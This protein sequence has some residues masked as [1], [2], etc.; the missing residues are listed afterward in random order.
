MG[1]RKFYVVWVGREPGIYEEW[2]DC[3]EQING[4]PGARYKAFDSQTAAT[5]AFRGDP[6]DQASIIEAIAAHRAEITKV[7]SRSNLFDI[8]EINLDAIAV[9]GACS[10]VPGPMEY[11]GVDVK[12]GIELFHVGPLDDGTNNVAEY[13]ALIHALAYLYQKGDR[14]TPVYSDSKIARGWVKNHGHRSKLERTPRNGLI[15]ELLD[16]ADNWIRT[17]QTENPILRWDTKAW[18]EIPADFGRK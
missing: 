10:G 13:L 7:E 8:P 12:S 3:H 4:F 5:I 1:K 16:R 11:R 15:F 6:D 17:H 2:S 9:D 14:T 18:G